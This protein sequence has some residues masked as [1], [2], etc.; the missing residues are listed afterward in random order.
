MKIP[1][2]ADWDEFHDSEIVDWKRIRTSVEHENTL[3]NHRVTWLLT[4]QGFLLAAFALVFQASTK[5][6]VT[7]QTQPYYKFIMA[8][9]ALTGILASAYL[10]LGLRAAQIQHDR[11]RDWW[12][13]RAKT[14]KGQ[15]PPVCGSNFPWLIQS[16]PYYSFPLVFVVAWLF[17]IPVILWAEI[18]PY[19]NQLGIFTLGLVGA[20]GLIVLGMLIGR[21]QP[22][23][24]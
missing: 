23:K 7:P 6:D 20:I 19:A 11:L 12:E 10:R 18:E 16:F 8:A 15:H 17:F 14:V 1:T 13:V 22:R 24:S 2:D 21:S 3:T 4:S 9:L 5:S